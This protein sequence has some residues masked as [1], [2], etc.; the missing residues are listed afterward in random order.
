MAVGPGSNSTTKRVLDALAKVPP[1]YLANFRSLTRD[2]WVRMYNCFVQESTANLNLLA[3]SDASFEGF[4][5]LARTDSKWSKGFFFLEDDPQ[6]V[7]IAG[8]PAIT[9][10]EPCNTIS[11]VAFY[12]SMFAI[13]DRSNTKSSWTINHDDVRGF[14]RGLNLMAF[15]SIYAHAS[16]T[17]EGG[18][19]DELTISIMAFTAYQ[20]LAKA[21]QYDTSLFHLSN[22]TRVFSGLR[23]AKELSRILL[24]EDPEKWFELANTL[25]VPRYELSFAGI[26]VFLVTLMFPTALVTVILSFLAEALVRG[27][28]EKIVIWTFV[29]PAVKEAIEMN[30]RFVPA[31]K[32]LVRI[33]EKKKNKYVYFC[34]HF[35]LLTAKIIP[36]F[37]YL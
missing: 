23:A 26:V 30:P 5:S 20:V 29:E 9:I 25:D 10:A 7:T 37:K 34:F 16:T 33:Y 4:L 1:G 13:C 18:F 35:A 32:V 12:R 17:S 19:M 6:S 31:Y 36:K 27:E 21:L 8:G 24:E 15:G 2:I 14:V 28:D 22:T 11:N 3:V